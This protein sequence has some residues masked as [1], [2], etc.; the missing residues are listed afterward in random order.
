MDHPLRAATALL[1]I[2]LA[3]G[4]DADV[5]RLAPAAYPEG[6][7]WHN[8]R[9]LYVEYAQHTIRA[10][11]GR[12]SAVLWRH[13]GCGPSSLIAFG[14]DH[15]LVACYDS[16]SVLELDAAWHEVRT[17]DRDRDGYAFQGPNDF[18]ADG[19]DGVYLSASGVY[20][21]K[22]PI[23]GAILHLTADGQL[24][25]VAETIHYANGL[26]LSA[27]GRSLLVAEMLAARLLSFEVLA[28]G[29]LGARRVWARLQDLARPT[30][31]ADAYNGPDGVKRAADGDLYIA[32][33][34][35]G[36][37]LVVSPAGR[38]RRILTVPT[39]FVTNVALDPSGNVYITG[40]FD[41]WHAPYPGALFRVA[42]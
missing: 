29:T 18:C 6:P 33:N 32:Q 31:G 19:H 16:N 13:A 20:D 5:R 28:D 10:W 39:P 36:R 4:A 7:L 21:L 26:T 22:A 35:S 30:P 1:L 25:R 11:D 41:Q 23:S 40:V 24:R 3:G 2:A 12:R 9:L 17:I 27:D 38:L 15:L 42:P 37:V 14:A 34:G 8:D